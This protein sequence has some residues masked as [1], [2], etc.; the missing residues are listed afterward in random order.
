MVRL[1][2]PVLDEFV[3]AAKEIGEMEVWLFGSALRS[4]RP[5]DLDVALLYQDRERVIQ[6]RG[7]A[8]W[9]FAVPPIDLIAFTVDEERHHEFLRSVRA[10]R[11]V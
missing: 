1:T 7:R 8:L 10:L 3:A 11:L 2:W 9:E 4:E 5:R 6:L